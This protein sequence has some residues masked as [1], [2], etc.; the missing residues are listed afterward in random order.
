MRKPCALAAFIL[1]FPLL[2]PSFALAYVDPGS[3]SYVVEVLIAMAVGIV[4]AI[5][6]YWR[7]FTGLFRRRDDRQE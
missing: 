6:L 2:F 4:F 7:K 5:K 1:F 3:G